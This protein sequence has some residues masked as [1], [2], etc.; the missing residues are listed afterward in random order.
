MGM[1]D[2]LKSGVKSDINWKVRQGVSD[3]LGKGAAK[4]FSN[5]SKNKCPKCKAPISEN[6]KVCGNCGTK[7]FLTCTQ[8]HSNPYG[9]KFCKEC[10]EKLK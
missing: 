9:T 3:V 2:N 4:L 7:L 1:L 8:G 5:K 6:D 10:G